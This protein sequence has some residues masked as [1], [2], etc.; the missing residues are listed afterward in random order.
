MIEQALLG[1]IAG[2]VYSVLGWYK[3][4]NTEQ[5]QAFNAKQAIATVVAGVIAG[6]LAGV[7]DVPMDTIIEVI[8]LAFGTIGATKVVAGNVIK[9]ATTE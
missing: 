7:G 5:R 8:T 1:L 6:T 2:F 4:L 3:K 9:K